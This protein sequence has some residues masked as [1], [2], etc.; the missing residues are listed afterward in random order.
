MH[1]L[2][3]ALA[4]VCPRRMHAFGSEKKVRRER[5]KRE[6]EDRKRRERKNFER[7]VRKEKESPSIV[8]KIGVQ[9][10]RRERTINT[11]ERNSKLFSQF[12]FSWR[13]IETSASRQVQIYIE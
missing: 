7:K 9:K 3:H 8:R 12:L 6:K 4:D 10:N 2:V 11:R 1:A 13:E 5:E